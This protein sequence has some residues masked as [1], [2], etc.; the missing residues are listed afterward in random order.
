MIAYARYF[1]ID[2]G[3]PHLRKVGRTSKKSLTGP[4]RVHACALRLTGSQIRSL[5][6]TITL[7]ASALLLVERAI[8]NTTSFQVVR[9]T[10]LILAHRKDFA[11][12]KGKRPSTVIGS[13][14]RPYMVHAVSRR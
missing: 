5:H 1:I 12:I 8:D 11:V 7:Q 10:R 14:L 3:L 6:P 4:I 9:S 2:S 13:G